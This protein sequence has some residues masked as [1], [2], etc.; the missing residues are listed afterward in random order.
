MFLIWRR[1]SVYSCKLILHL[2]CWNWKLFLI[3][4]IY[5]NERNKKKIGLL[6][7]VTIQKQRPI[8]LSSK[9]QLTFCCFWFYN[10]IVTDLF[11]DVVSSV[12]PKFGDLSSSAWSV[13]NHWSLEVS[14]T[15]QRRGREVRVRAGGSA[16]FPRL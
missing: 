9:S 11:F 12:E 6:K 16:S 2:V 7:V 13:Q 10:N 4:Y 15:L 14:R 5:D 3:H 1:Y 8:Y